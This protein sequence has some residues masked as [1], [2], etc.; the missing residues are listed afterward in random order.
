M[1]SLD[2]SVPTLAP[3][4]KEE[5]LLQLLPQLPRLVCLRLAGLL[6]ATDEVCREIA[7]LTHLQRLDLNATMVTSTGVSN[8][9]TSPSAS[10]LKSLHLACH[11]FQEFQEDDNQPYP[12]FRELA[13][14][15]GLF[16]GNLEDIDVSHSPVDDEAFGSLAEGGLPL[17]RLKLSRCRGLTP[18]G[19]ALILQEPAMQ[20]L[21]VLNLTGLAVTAQL[22]ASLS[23]LPLLSYLIL[24]GPNE[25]DMNMVLCQQDFVA[26]YQVQPCTPGIISPSH[27]GK[28][29]DLGWLS[30]QAGGGSSCLEAPEAAKTKPGV[31]WS[32]LE[33]AIFDK[34][35]V[36]SGYQ[37]LALEGL[38]VGGGPAKLKTL[39][40]LEVW[41]R[42]RS[43]PWAVAP[44]LPVAEAAPQL[45]TLKLGWPLSPG[46]ATAYTL[47]VY[48]SGL[49]LLYGGGEDMLGKAGR[50]ALRAARPGLKVKIGP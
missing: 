27:K 11:P 29:Q 5:V 43:P 16:M 14:G 46:E 50:E 25:T 1:T 45:A 35:D 18:D 40:L 47:H 38:L 17:K 8:L 3:S 7:K 12:N 24:C 49:D 36:Q 37:R 28:L 10:K 31:G 9:M 15:F 44:L 48:R 42:N 6:G 2:L 21:A 19:V 22:M 26:K 4:L 13:Q 33:T 30:T 41:N 34:L 32:S 23:A 20:Y 39:S